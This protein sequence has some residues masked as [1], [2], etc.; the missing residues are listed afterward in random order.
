MIKRLALKNW[1]S[2]LDSEFIFSKG[3]NVL[4]GRMGSGKSS[5]MDAISFAL[6]GTFPAL[7]S[8]KVKLDDC[9]MNKPSQKEKARVEL[10]FQIGDDTYL[11]VREV[12]RGKGTTLAEIR[13]NGK[14][15]DA[16]NSNR[17][18]EI[19]TEVLGM[20]YD[21][22]SKAVYS[23]QNQ[24]D[25]FLQIPKGKRRESIDALLGINRFEDARKSAVS[26]RNFVKSR[27]SDRESEIDRL[28]EEELKSRMEALKKELE[29][30]ETR[31]KALSGT[32]SQLEKEKEVLGY[33]VKRMEDSRKKLEELDR[34]I[35]AVNAE[36]GTLLGR[37]REREEK[38]GKYFS[39]DL[40]SK[41][42]STRKALDDL[43]RKERDLKSKISEI[44]S[45]IGSMKAKLAE[46]D[47]R[48]ARIERART[49]LEGIIKKISKK[50]EVESKLDSIKAD[51]QMTRDQVSKIS[52]ELDSLTG[53]RK[54]L[55]E[56]EGKC[57]VCGR[58]LDEHTKEELLD[59]VETRRKDLLKKKSE[60]ENKIKDLESTRRSLE[61][62]VS[63]LTMLEGK[64]VELEKL[65]K[66]EIPSK[67]E[68]E[69]QLSSLEAERAKLESSLSEI[70]S[71]IE[72]KQNLIS[73]IEK[74][75]MIRDEYTK[76][77]SRIS[78]LK[79]LK[80]KLERVRESIKFDESDYQKLR[81]EYLKASTE[82]AKAKEESLAISK[83][84]GDKNKSISD[85]ETT[86]K[87]IKT[88]KEEIEIFRS[89]EK[90]LGI[91]AKALE[92]SQALLREEFIT[93]VNSALEDIWPR[94]YPYED[95][96]SARLFVDGKDY[97]LQLQ[98]RDDK[99]VNVEGL[100]SG[101]ERSTAALALRVAFSLVLT[102]NLNWMILDEPTH[103]LDKEGVQ[104]LAKTLREHLPSLVEQI[105]IITHDEDM[106]EAV[107]G[108]LYKLE[109]DKGVDE[110]TRVILVSSGET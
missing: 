94:L 101:G 25:Y 71:E 8:R 53:R 17:V 92:S 29:E 107:S 86:L 34:K 96:K 104:T 110:P 37:V 28:K 45:T 47:Q 43:R 49:E 2:H 55:E 106:E 23:E 21:L 18:T 69:K 51:L 56:A 6:Y 75:I 57:P 35:S 74:L 83:M 48:R 59:E 90:D 58:P 16:G 60:L 26:L 46:I 109:R 11:V 1:R 85:L 64:L 44:S 65:V 32:I 97:V 100:V 108:T 93:A 14:L 33:Q 81:E 102:Q 38:Y 4:I 77:K 98:R 62:E 7:Q 89:V 63:K 24:I 99:W 79:T 95:Y 61:L 105:F 22:F 12:T 5:A 78:E 9:I 39:L 68:L 87:A 67:E 82:L 103:N 84:I 54:E 36:M 72:R 42:D 50:K 3:T 88:M 13:K 31:G 40:D 15:I 80:E 70:G 66:E 52:A 20:N 76:D 91:M 30:L 19:V 27:V 41:L 73:K 10:E